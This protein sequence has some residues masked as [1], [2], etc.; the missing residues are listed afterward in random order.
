MHTYILYICLC[1]VSNL[2]TYTS[3]KHV[4]CTKILSQHQRMNLQHSLNVCLVRLHTN[5][6]AGT[7][8]LTPTPAYFDIV[9]ARTIRT[10]SQKNV[11]IRMCERW[12]HSHHIC[13][14]SECLCSNMLPLYEQWNNNFIFMCTNKLEYINC[15]FSQKGGCT[16]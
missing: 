10:K 2:T 9:P 13:V 7:R 6:P 8:G 4:S 5:K 14:N 11:L 12:K 1:W 3:Y 15:H 16:N